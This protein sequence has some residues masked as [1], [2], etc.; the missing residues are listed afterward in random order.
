M[1]IPTKESGYSHASV[2]IL[3]TCLFLLLPKATYPYL[4]TKADT[5]PLLLREYAPPSKK[6]SGFTIKDNLRLFS[7]PENRSIL[8][9]PISDYF[10]STDTIDSN[11]P[12]FSLFRQSDLHSKDPLAAL[13]YADLRIKKLLDEYLQVQKRAEQLLGSAGQAD[14]L[15]HRERPTSYRTDTEQQRTDDEP[16][17]YQALQHIRQNLALQPATVAT[18]SDGETEAS[19]SSSRPINELSSPGTLQLLHNM[20]IMPPQSH[21]RSPQDAKSAYTSSAPDPARR[22]AR[23][24]VPEVDMAPTSADCS[25]KL[26]WI[27]NIPFKLLDFAI[28]HKILTAIAGL[29]VLMLGNIIFGSRS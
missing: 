10:V 13:L 1:P 8:L 17:I 21:F 4:I 22:P 6:E 2:I 25:F 19:P 24:T 7:Q 9:L 20:G 23:E 3:A 18:A 11:L 16:E 12:V 5:T 15:L 29:L 27:L 28:A 14:T 26:P